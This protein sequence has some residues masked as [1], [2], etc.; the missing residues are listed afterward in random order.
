MKDRFQIAADLR[1]IAR[2][3]RIKNENPFKAAAYE[4][5]AAALEKLDGDLSALVKARRLQEIPGIGSALAAIIREKFRRYVP[6]G[7]WTLY[8]DD[9]LVLEADPHALQK[10]VERAGLELVGDKEI[11]DKEKEKDSRKEEPLS[12]EAVVTADSPLVGRTLADLR[13]RQRHQVNV[14]ALSRRGNRSRTRM[15]RTRFQPGVVI[16]L[17]RGQRQLRIEPLDADLHR[18]S[19]LEVDRECGALLVGEHRFRLIGGVVHDDPDR[20]GRERGLLRGRERE[21][22]VVHGR[23]DLVHRG[24]DIGDVLEYA[25]GVDDRGPV[26][27]PRHRALQ[28]AGANDRRRARGDDARVM[29][30]VLEDPQ[31]ARGEALLVR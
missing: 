26:S 14:L 8:E 27:D 2:L 12:V 29:P 9:V 11:E 3:L 23:G 19:V 6:S 15:R 21:L 28:L 17:R 24:G 30:A 5:G 20:P 18:G 4:R 7:Y 10:A 16:V 22:Q 1:S 25:R 31:R 13:L